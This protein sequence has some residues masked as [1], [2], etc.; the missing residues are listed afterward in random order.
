MKKIILLRTSPIL[1]GWAL[2]GDSGAGHSGGWAL[3]EKSEVGHSRETLG[4]GT[5]GR[6]W[7]WALQ[8]P[9]RLGTPGM[10]WDERGA[11]WARR[12][13]ELKNLTAPHRHIDAKF[14]PA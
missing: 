13:V 14:A 9:L 10:R 8:G 6:L 5:P 3:Q 1:W 11:D 12:R 4:L 2:Q 7:G